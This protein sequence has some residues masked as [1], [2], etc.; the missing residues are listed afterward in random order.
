MEVFHGKW[1]EHCRMSRSVA[2]TLTVSD[3]SR[4][5]SMNRTPTISIAFR[6]KTDQ[7]KSVTRSRIEKVKIY[8]PFSPAQ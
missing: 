4:H 8:F 6:S 3:F 5:F 2:I 1:Y 7:L